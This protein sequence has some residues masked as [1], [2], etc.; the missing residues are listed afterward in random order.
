[1]YSLWTSSS[2]NWWDP[3]PTSWNMVVCPIKIYYESID[4]NAFYTIT[5]KF[6]CLGPEDCLFT[7]K[8]RSMPTYLNEGFIDHNIE[9]LTVTA[10]NVL[11]YVIRFQTYLAATW[12]PTCLPSMEP[13]RHIRY[14]RS[15]I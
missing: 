3:S 2:S 12:L 11:V 7:I 15:V 1:M 10:N 4:P 14:Y 13:P 8:F 9:T 6:I 5:A